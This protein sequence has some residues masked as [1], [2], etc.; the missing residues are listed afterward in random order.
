MLKERPDA[1]E[2]DQQN[3]RDHAITGLEP[4]PVRLVGISRMVSI[5]YFGLCFVGIAVMF[6]VVQ[7]GQKSALHYK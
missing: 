1:I 6:R 3:T 5:I 4:L 2:K 7:S